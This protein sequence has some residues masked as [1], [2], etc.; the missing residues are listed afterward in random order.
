MKEK[1]EHNNDPWLQAWE[2]Y[3]RQAKLSS[4]LTEE[5]LMRLFTDSQNLP[6]VPVPPLPESAHPSRWLRFAAVIVLIV[7]GALL[8]LL[9]HG[10]SDAGTPLQAQLS[11][12]ANADITLSAAAPSSTPPAT[13]SPATLRRPVVAKAAI[14]N[15]SGRQPDASPLPEPADSLCQP[16]TT[17]SFDNVQYTALYCNNETC[18]TQNYLYQAFVALNLA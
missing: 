16:C 14:N 10:T 15:D 1:K 8:L 2:N 7:V 11:A 12:P 13:P 17:I 3:N 18:D 4:S 9:N 5:E 6:P